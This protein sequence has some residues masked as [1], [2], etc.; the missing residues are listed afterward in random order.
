MAMNEEEELYLKAILDGGNIL[1][2]VDPG[3][4][5]KIVKSIKEHRDEPGLCAFFGDG[6]Y[7]ALYAG[8]LLDFKI[9]KDIEPMVNGG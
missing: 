4:P 6:T 5:F 3:G 7:A 1:V 2:W 9:L 8:S